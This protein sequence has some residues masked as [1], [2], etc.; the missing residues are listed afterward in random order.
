MAISAVLVALLELGLHIFGYGYP[1]GFFVKI[2]SRDAYTTNQKF[3]WRFFPPP[4]ARTP[5]I[6][7][8]PGRKA[9]NTYRIFVLGESAAMGTPEP[10][11]SFGRI[12][13]AM[14]QQRYP[15]VNFEVVNAAM[16]AINSHVMV[17]I[18]NDCAKRQPDLFLVYAGNNEVVGPYGAGTVFTQESSSLALIRT[19][20]WFRSTLTGQLLENAV[21]S[22]RNNDGG[23]SKWEGMSMFRD[24]L[25]PADDPRMEHIYANFGA[26]LTEVCRTARKV[27]AAVVISTVATN[28]KDCAPFASVHRLKLSDADRARWQTTYN[29]AVE[30]EK[31]GQYANATG[32]FFEAARL[33]DRFAELQFRLAR[34]LLALNKAAD[35]REHFVLAR[36]L[37]ALRFRAD[38]RIIQTIRQV[39]ANL[40]KD[41]VRLADAN[42][43]FEHSDRSHYGIPGDELL[44]E[45]VHPNFSGNYVIAETFFRGMEA[46]LPGWVKQKAA[47]PDPISENEAAELLPFTAFDRYR[48]AAGIFAMTSQ[49]P[50]TGQFDFAAKKVAREQELRNL[51]HDGTGRQTL[52][53]TR[54]KYVSAL[55]K[56]PNDIEKRS[57]FAAVLSKCGNHAG[58][59]AE[60]RTLIARV[61]GVARWHQSLADELRDQDKL[62]EALESARSALRLD[63]YLQAVHFTLGE[64][65]ERTGRWDEAVAEFEEWLRLNPESEEGHNHLGTVLRRRHQFKEAF[66]HYSE[67]L[68]LKPDYAEVHNNWGVALEGLGEIQQAIAHY[69]EAVRLKP[70]FAE[71]QANWGVALDRL[72]QTREAIAHYQEALRLKPGFAT[73]QNN[74][75]AALERLGEIEQAISHYQEALRLKPDFADAKANLQ[76]ALSK[77]PQAG[78]TYYREPRQ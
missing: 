42:H 41:G 73:V 13:A 24:H 34:C 48:S 31:A 59:A 29:S 69:Q 27:G 1:T 2:A 23:R 20:I 54:T 60:W 76:L 32:Q 30:S 39:G 46:N 14:L 55:Q 75:G 77:L 52:E 68:R 5:V 63:P 22:L 67:A 11:F 35:A 33:D 3:G 47:G 18:A 19:G 53:D 10:G 65:F 26:N 37:D 72:G 50:F 62:E 74:W 43:A 51:A 36:D 4:L 38:T 21:G 78:K 49:P 66:E 70:D 45:H 9:P 8:L 64:I 25:V 44:Y 28:L 56:D 58:A 71:V 40:A 16:T 7:D 61:P 12:L 6:C 17:P 57:R 15:G